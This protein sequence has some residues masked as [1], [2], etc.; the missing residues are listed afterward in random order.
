MLVYSGSTACITCIACKHLTL[1]TDSSSFRLF[2]F[3]RDI[4]GAETF[5]YVMLDI[6]NSPY[7]IYNKHGQSILRITYTPL[8]K[9]SCSL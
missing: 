7:I 5:Y 2:S 9:L 6:N 1:M 8:G 4:A 3:S